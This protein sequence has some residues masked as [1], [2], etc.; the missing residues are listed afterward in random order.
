MKKSAATDCRRR[1]GYKN[2]NALSF[3]NASAQEDKDNLN[4][5]DALAEHGVGAYA[6]FL[7][8]VRVSSGQ[9][10]QT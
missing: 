7:G 2:T 4:K 1:Q 6:D 8:K 3:I 10:A 5:V 9:C